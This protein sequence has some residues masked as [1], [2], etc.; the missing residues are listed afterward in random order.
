MNDDEM[1][2]QFWAR[3]RHADRDQSRLGFGLETRVLARVRESRKARPL[4]LLQ[5]AGRFC[6]GSLCAVLLLG[7]WLPSTVN[8]LEFSNLWQ[9][10]ADDDGAGLETFFNGETP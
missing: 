8:A 2:D 4:S 7:M 6:L 10:A 1:I 3:L 5:L 9:V